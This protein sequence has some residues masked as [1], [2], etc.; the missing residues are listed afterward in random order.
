MTLSAKI[1]N[2]ADEHE[3]NSLS[4]FLQ[5]STE[6]EM[7]QLDDAAECLQLLSMVKYHSHT[8]MANDAMQHPN[9]CVS[10]TTAAPATSYHQ[11]A[12]ENTNDAER[13]RCPW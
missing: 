2:L 7:V 5:F 1:A 6:D 8:G 10:P 3:Y 11:L 9:R 12:S 13:V 4:T